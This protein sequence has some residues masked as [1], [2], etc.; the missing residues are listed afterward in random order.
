[1]NIL[2]KLLLLI[3]TISNSRTALLDKLGFVHGE[4]VYKV[5]G[6]KMKFM[7]RAGTEDMA[8]IV[9][10]A[11]GSE[12]NLKKIK[13]H[14]N[15]IIF[16][17]GGHIGTFSIFISNFFKNKCSIYVFEPDRT[18]YKILKH[19]IEINKVSSITAKNIAISDY[20]GKGFLRNEKMNT[21]AYFL[22]DKRKDS[23]CLVSTLPSM[24]RENNVKRIDLLKID[25]EGGE[26]K[27]FL[28]KDS[29][30]FIKK[31]VHY[32]F[33]EYHNINKRFNYSLIEKIIR[34][35]FL[36]L[37]LKKNVLTLENLNWKY[38]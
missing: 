14:Q 34:K 3:K 18:N 24:V 4:I 28:H 37:S 20:N 6:K 26:Y 27:I 1:M 36:I 15:P 8:E 7:A 11:S 9:V 17:L 13:L 32:I 33:M 31:N 23:N 30:D 10:V 29:F 35:D 22:D 5:R 38:D 2:F 16:D 21:D 25:I 19:N 12:Y